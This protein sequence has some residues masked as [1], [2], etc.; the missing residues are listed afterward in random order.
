M[1]C[2]RS[3]GKIYLAANENIVKAHSATLQ[4]TEL[5]MEEGC[6]TS[7]HFQSKKEGS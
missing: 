3:K 7:S 1:G 6:N 5:S 2:G 4:E